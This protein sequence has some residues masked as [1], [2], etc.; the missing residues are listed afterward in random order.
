M[1]I[2]HGVSLNVL[3]W[4]LF[5]IKIKKLSKYTTVKNYISPPLHVGKPN[6]GDRSALLS[7]I[8]DMLDRRWFSNNGPLVQEFEKRISKFLGVKHV[9]AMCNATAAAWMI[10][11][12]DGFENTMAFRVSIC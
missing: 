3:H 9:V 11:N 1:R 4:R 2:C 7:R 6:L 10:S 5:E 8:N 12:R